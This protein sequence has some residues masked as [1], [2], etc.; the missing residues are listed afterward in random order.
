MARSTH[1]QQYQAFLRLL[2]NLR[3]RAGVTQNV[4]AKRL[5]NTQTFIS[6]V[7]RG[8]RRLDIVEFVEVCEALDIDPKAAFAEFLRRRHSQPPLAGK[9]VR[10]RG[11]LAR[12]EVMRKT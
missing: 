11:S 1:D 6:K 3:L 7:E 2:R 9:L 4:L 5:G 10:R 12:S 8:E